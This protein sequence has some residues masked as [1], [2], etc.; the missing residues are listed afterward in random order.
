VVV[1]GLV[2][3]SLLGLATDALV[4]ALERKALAWRHG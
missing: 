3:Y 4:R 2:L 1:G